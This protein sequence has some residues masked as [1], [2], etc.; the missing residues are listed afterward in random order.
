MSIVKVLVYDLSRGMAMQMSEAILG[1]RIDGIWHSGVLVYG[2]EYFFGG[3]IQ[4][5]RE[6]VFPASNGF[7][8]Q[9]VHE[10]GQT[11][12]TRDDLHA[13]LRS[14]NSRYTQ[15]T[16]NLITNNCNNF[17]DDICRFLTGQG[18]PSYIVDLPRTVFST[19]GGMMLRPM[20]ENMQNAIQGGGGGDP[21]GS[22]NDSGLDSSTSPVSVSASSSPLPIETPIVRSLSKYEA[23]PSPFVSGDSDVSVL[24]SMCNKILNANLPGMEVGSSTSSSSSSSA[25]SAEEKASISAAIAVITSRS[26]TSPSQGPCPTLAFIA[27]ARLLSECP[28]V[29][30]ASLFILRLMVLGPVGSEEASKLP[31]EIR[32]AISSILKKLLEG[33]SSFS[34]ISSIVMAMCTI[35]NLLTSPSGFALL[36]PDSDTTSDA[37]SLHGRLLDC[38]VS[39]LSNDRVEMRQMSAAALSNFT[40]VCS[41]EQE[42][43][44]W[45]VPGAVV[46]AEDAAATS[47]LHPTAVQTICSALESLVDESDVACRERR[48]AAACRAL[49]SCGSNAIALAKDLG[50]ADIARDMLS[51][52][53]HSKQENELLLDLDLLL[54]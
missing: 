13:Y 39:N 20:F 42:G 36:F 46:V 1:Q 28:S 40:L 3:G 18:I 30:M 51:R 14:I 47:E 50:F 44:G 9:R 26:A 19:P 6:G 4:F 7:Q 22:Y 8:P 31:I 49:R 10:V 41:R 32:P 38:I 29:Q 52:K 17:A 15:Q 11:R 45:G 43:A 2:H 12:V 35:S 54:S 48:L 34:S 16:Y 23:H 37:E 25:L 33:R 24:Q 27:L 21:F 5:L 53:D